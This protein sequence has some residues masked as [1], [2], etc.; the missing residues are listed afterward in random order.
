MCGE[1]GYLRGR[2]TAVNSLIV[3]NC[4]GVFDLNDMRTQE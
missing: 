1:R 3:A 2:T 4:T